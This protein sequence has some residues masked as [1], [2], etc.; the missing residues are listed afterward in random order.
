MVKELSKQQRKVLLLLAVAIL[1]GAGRLGF[2]A[3]SRGTLE[4]HL[5]APVTAPWP[6]PT[7]DGQGRGLPHRCWR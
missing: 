7:I 6:A 2:R 4:V 1:L 5:V 3:F